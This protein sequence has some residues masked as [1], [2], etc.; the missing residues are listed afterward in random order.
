MRMADRGGAAPYWLGAGQLE[1]DDSC[2]VR[3]VDLSHRRKRPLAR[4]MPI[5]R[6][7]ITDIC[8]SPYCVHA[9]GE[10][11]VSTPGV[12]VGGVGVGE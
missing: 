11:G 3:S 12:E 2:P 6:W 4:H 9:D 1:A 7:L 10:A 8:C 5:K